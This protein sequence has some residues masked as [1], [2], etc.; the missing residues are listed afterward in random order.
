MN[1]LSI[2]VFTTK[3]NKSVVP[4]FSINLLLLQQCNNDIAGT[5]KYFALIQDLS[6]LL[7]RQ[8]ANVKHQQVLLR[9]LLNNFKTTKFRETRDR[10][11]NFK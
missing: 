5:R 10:L 1:N 7:C 6:R 4:L 8:T 9:T 11:S 2:N 3:N